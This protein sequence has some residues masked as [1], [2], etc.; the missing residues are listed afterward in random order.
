M[1][2]IHR[3][4][5]NSPHE[6]QWRGSFMFSL[7]SAWTNGWANH[8]EAG[9]LRHHRGHYYSNE[10]NIHCMLYCIHNHRLIHI[11]TLNAVVMC[12]RNHIHWV[13]WVLE[14]RIGYITPKSTFTIIR[15]RVHRSVCFLREKANESGRYA[16]FSLYRVLNMFW[17][18]RQVD[19]T[20]QDPQ[21]AFI[22]TTNHLTILGM[23]MA[24]KYHGLV[25]YNPR[26]DHKHIHMYI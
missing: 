8:R 7:I 11:C 3:S 19:D 18:K 6:G 2:G 20:I 23:S 5:V 21:M 10:I 15:I 12:F 22:L 9:H 1:W 26:T 16:K 24:S 4:Q 17:F 13:R 14:S 25:I